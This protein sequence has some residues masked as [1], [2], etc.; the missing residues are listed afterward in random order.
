MMVT[1][2]LPAVVYAAVATE[3]ARVG[4]TIEAVVAQALAD[5]YRLETT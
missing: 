1:L 3:A 4:E 5:R 2:N